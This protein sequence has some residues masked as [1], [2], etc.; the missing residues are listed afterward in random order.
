MKLVDKKIVKTDISNT[1]FGT[2]YR[3][4]P[5]KYVD[6]QLEDLEDRYDYLAARMDA[7]E[8]RISDLE[9]EPNED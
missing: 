8:K 7:L 3:Y 5:N 9:T 1:G 2:L 6:T 4:E